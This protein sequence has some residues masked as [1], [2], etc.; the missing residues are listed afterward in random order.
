LFDP[1]PAVRVRW[2]HNQD[3]PLPPEVPTGENPPDGAVIDYYLRSAV[4]GPVTISIH[5]AS[6]AAVREYTSVA[7]PPD[8]R[9]P[10]VPEYW[11]KKPVTTSTA[12]GMHRL[13]WDLR[14]PTPPSLD[15]DDE[16]E[17]ADTISYGIIATAVIGETPK[18]Q[19]V[20]S[21]VVPGTYEVR[22]AAG[23]QTVTRQL[24]V[25]NDPRSEA[26]AEDLALQLKY[27]RALATGIETSRAAIDTARQ[28]RVNVREIASGKPSLE[29]AVATF[30][31]AGAEVITAF[32]SNRRLARL[33]G[34]LQF[35]DLKP[36]KSTIAA[37]TAA[38]TQ[39]DSALGRFRELLR[40]DLTVLNGELDRVGIGAIQTPTAPPATACGLVR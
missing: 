17:E 3:T 35:A 11:F 27:E 7:P 29:Q 5:D 13:V 36:T 40:K 31:R 16:G 2:D 6:G 28:L 1:A 23:G 12:T 34:S 25:T 19:P 20:G 4:T 39:V 38:C 26:T 9:M 33:L 8:T 30:D 10:N 37:V 24:S 32:A 21:L 18:Q 15:V 14:Y 22:L